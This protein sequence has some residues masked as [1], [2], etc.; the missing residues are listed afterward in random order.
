MKIIFY[1]APSYGGPHEAEISTRF[2]FTQKSIPESPKMGQT[3]NIKIRD[4]STFSFSSP[5]QLDYLWVNLSRPVILLFWS[6]VCFL[7][8]LYMALWVPFLSRWTSSSKCWQ[9]V[10]H[11]WA[12]SRLIILRWLSSTRLFDVHDLQRF[13]DHLISSVISSTKQSTDCKWELKFSDTHRSF[14]FWFHWHQLLF[15]Q[16]WTMDQAGSSVST[17]SNAYLRAQ[18]FKNTSLSQIKAQICTTVNQIT[19]FKKHSLQSSIAY[20]ITKIPNLYS[21]FGC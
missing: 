12:I 1:G 9:H 15:A 16:M 7:L 10:R 6:Y 14:S 5:V 18:C 13:V 2:P 4:K 8:S 19:L 3:C 20:V 17:R 11:L 21:Q